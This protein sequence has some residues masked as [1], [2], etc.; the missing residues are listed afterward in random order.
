MNPHPPNDLDYYAILGV[1]PDASLAEIKQAHRALVRRYHPDLFALNP[2]VAWEAEILMSEINRAY[3]VLSNSQKRRIYDRQR[4]EQDA[5]WQAENGQGA[6]HAQTEDGFLADKESVLFAPSADAH[7]FLALL[8]WL[9]FQRARSGHRQTM[10]ALS[11]LLLA[12]IPFCVA[13]IV[14]SLF[15]QLGSVTGHVFLFGLSAVLAYPLILVPALARLMLPIRYQPLLS[16]KQKIIGTP[17]MLMAALLLGWIWV[18][19]AD[20]HGTV[21]NPLDLYWWCGLI[22]LTCLSLAAL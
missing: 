13:I 4:R 18:V 11:K 5:K 22:V 2:E 21:S 9:S 20:R 19:V 10:G 16:L 14:S 7:W 3:D 17:I 1:A 15:F 8:Q 12:P 6:A